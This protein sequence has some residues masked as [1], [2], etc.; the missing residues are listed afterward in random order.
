MKINRI[1]AATSACMLASTAGFFAFVPASSAATTSPA[2]ARIAPPPQ[3][4]SMAERPQVSSGGYT[5][6]DDYVQNIGWQSW[7]CDGEIA[8]TAGQ[9]LRMEALAIVSYDTDGFCADAHVQS[10]GWQGWA[11]AND[12]DV[13]TVGTEGQSLRMEALSL[14]PREGT[15]C[16]DAQVQ[17]I[18]WMGWICGSEV[19]V[20]TTGESLRMEAI[21]I[22]G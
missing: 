10:I 16:A 13:L 17:N 18:G 3:K 19:T 1:A 20:G 8:G 4:P 22:T 5:C 11:C 14:E 7:V 21:A 2:T 9:S 15:V 12:G 6:Y